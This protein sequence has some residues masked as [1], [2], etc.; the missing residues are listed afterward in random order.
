MQWLTD[1]QA[2]H[3]DNSEIVVEGASYEGRNITGIHIWGSGGKDTKPAAVFHSTI[4]AREWI[5]TMVGLNLFC[6]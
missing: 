2:A 6:S 3:P 4:H 1:L 5:T